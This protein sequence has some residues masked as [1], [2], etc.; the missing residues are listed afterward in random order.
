[1]TIKVER[2]DLTG[3]RA[4]VI[5]NVPPVINALAEAYTGVGAMVTTIDCR[6]R[7]L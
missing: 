4:L 7:T 2:F 1:M 6:V 3:Q 5:G